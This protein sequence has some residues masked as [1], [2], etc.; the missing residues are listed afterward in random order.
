V[1]G[2]ALNDPRLDWALLDRFGF[3]RNRFELDQERIRTGALSAATAVVR[4]R[5]EPVDDLVVL[6]AAFAEVGREALAAGKVAKVVLNGGMATRFGGVVKGVVPV[7]D[8]HSFIALSA[9][10]A[11]TSRE[12]FGRTVP[13][14]L[15]NSFAT[16]EAT[17]AHLVEHR[18]F[19][20]ADRDLLRFTQS[21]SIRMN[22]DGSVFVGKDGLPSYHAPGH[23]DFFTAIRRSGVLA[24]LMERGVE[25][26]FFAN[27]DNL[28]ATIDAAVLGHHIASRRAM[29]VE[30]TEKQRTASGAWDKGGA[31]AKVDG[32]PQLVEGFRFPPE[33]PQER[34][35]D[36]STNNMVFTA[37][38][39]DREV[40]LERH[41]VKKEVDGRPALQLESITCEASAV[42]NTDGS[43]LLP[44]LVLRVPR[45][46]LEGRFFPVKEPAD[47]E[48]HR[49]KLRDR[50]SGV[51]PKG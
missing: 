8:G 4:G 11:L 29:T 19:G 46:G 3:D 15:M 22:E 7:F 35:T 20:L 32:F 44:L 45:E 33:F 47:L 12:R 2:R 27:V 14:V 24:S 50:M 51:M 39:I 36:F 13:L 37:S 48:A 25:Y 1:A 30:V 10:D 31:P 23:G 42:R 17:E 38:A 43:A 28:G 5:I 34:L 41:V 9:F 21:I 49:A 26:L 18:C 40:A 6:G 16:E